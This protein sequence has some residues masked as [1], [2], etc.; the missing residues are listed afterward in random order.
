MSELKVNET[1]IEGVFRLELNSFPDQRGAFVEVWQSAK[2]QALGLPTLHPSQLGVSHSKK[3][4]IRGIHAEPWEKLIH[5]AVGSIFVAISD[6]RAESTTFGKVET[7]ELDQSGALFLP[8]GVG[9]SF[10]A[11]TDNV[12]YVYFVTGLYDVAKAHTGGYIAIR[13]DDPDLAINWPLKEIIV[14]VKDQNN[15][16]LREAFPGKF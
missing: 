2:M 10:Q 8:K 3:G 16:S 7:F 6:L 1:G 4:V 14:S 12:A 9:N 5:P 15:P 13:Y 11:L